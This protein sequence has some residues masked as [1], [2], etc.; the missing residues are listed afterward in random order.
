MLELGGLI[1]GVSAWKKKLLCSLMVQ[2]QIR[3]YHLPD[4][5]RVTWL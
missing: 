2:Q 3:M 1:K 4:G 5:S